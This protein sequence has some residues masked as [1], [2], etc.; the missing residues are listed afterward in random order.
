[1]E[2]SLAAAVSLSTPVKGRNWEDEQMER[3]NVHICERLH[4]HLL[5]LLCPLCVCV[6]V[7]VWGGGGGQPRGET[8]HVHQTAQLE[9]VPFQAAQVVGVHLED[10]IVVQVLCSRQARH[11][12]LGGAAHP[13][14]Q[15]MQRSP[16]MSDFD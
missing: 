10:R 15:A 5:C 14:A 7:C 13:P 1:M 6:C 8:T 11:L 12:L 2:Q 4:V 16:D 3:A 9:V